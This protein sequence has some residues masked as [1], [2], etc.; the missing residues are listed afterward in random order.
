MPSIFRGWIPTVSGALSFSAL[1]DANY[2]PRA[3]SANRSDRHTRYLVCFRGRDCSDIVLPFKK[4]LGPKLLGLQ[5]KLWFVCIASSTSVIAGDQDTIN[6]RVF[7]FSNKTKWNDELL[8]ILRSAQNRL[9]A[10]QYGI[11]GALQNYFQQTFDELIDE[12]PSL[13]SFNVV[14]AISRKGFCEIHVEDDMK[15][16]NDAPRIPDIQPRRNHVTHI[17]A[18]QIF[19]FLRDIGHRHQHHNP[20]TDT[21]VDVW[22]DNPEDPF[23][24]KL[25]TLFS[26]YRKV[27]S[28]KRLR[29]RSSFASSLGVVAYADTFRGIIEF[30]APAAERNRLPKFYSEN[31]TS[32]IQAIDEEM[33]RRHEQI[34]Y[35]SQITRELLLASFGLIIAITAIFL[36]VDKK[37]DATPSYT[38]YFIAKMLATQPII[39]LA[40]I[41]GIILSARQVHDNVA[42]HR[43]VRWLFRL[44]QPLKLSLVITIFSL[45]TVLIFACIYLIV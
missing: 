19:F 37:V 24:W 33:R 21:I 42:N 14:F 16:S 17:L 3:I 1:G 28:Y 7:I 25:Q 26:L 38:L 6:G 5:G 34:Q 10:Y 36:V 44:L 40:L 39:T 4:I 12:L 2:L 13:S 18:A 8:P 43:L 9:R 30:D 23:E 45:A 31:V 29:E 22:P 27:I 15:I 35:A 41:G 32:S 20:N 11:D